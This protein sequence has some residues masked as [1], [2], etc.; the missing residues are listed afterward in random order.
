MS[1]QREEVI[2]LAE[3]CGF[4]TGTA[5]TVRE[6]KKMLS[7]YAYPEQIIQFA[8][9]IAAAM[10]PEIDRLKNNQCSGHFRIGCNYMS[11]CNTICNKCGHVHNA[12]TGLAYIQQL[13]AANQ[14]NKELQSENETCRNLMRIK[15][16][17]ND[18]FSQR[19]KEL[20]ATM[21]QVR[22]TYNQ[23]IAEDTA[24]RNEYLDEIAKLEG[25]KK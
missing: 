25:D 7:Y 5:H 3:A 8:A 13:N 16:E 17:Q 12:D 23:I 2:A 20:E 10:Q 1:K 19:N 11:G 4:H 6:G 15:Q 21:N 14:R 18:A 9:K 22:S 24:T